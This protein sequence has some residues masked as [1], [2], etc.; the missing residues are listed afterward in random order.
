MQRVKHKHSNTTYCPTHNRRQS[1]AE[2]FGLLFCIFYHREPSG[3]S[4]IWLKMLKLPME[5]SG[6][7]HVN[8]H[9]L[10][11]FVC[12]FLMGFALFLCRGFKLCL[13]GSKA[14]HCGEWDSASP[15]FKKTK[16]YILKGL[17]SILLHGVFCTILFR[18]WKS[19]NKRQNSNEGKIIKLFKSCQ[20][21][22][23]VNIHGDI[24]KRIRLVL[25]S[26]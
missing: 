9:G 16:R 11:V 23:V 3:E 26:G 8:Q 20:F 21:F 4:W 17:R 19:K 12:V 7:F 18:K 22:F 25:R 10:A 14:V 1:T 5:G 2:R 24:E 6:C 13:P 15:F